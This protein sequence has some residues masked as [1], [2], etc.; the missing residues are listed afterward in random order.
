MLWTATTIHPSLTAADLRR[1][2]PPG[3]QQATIHT[4]F[5]MKEAAL[6]LSHNESYDCFGKPDHKVFQSDVLFLENF[7]RPIC[8]SLK[9]IERRGAPFLG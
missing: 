3:S 1:P 2:D 7:L 4:R 8:I 6:L 5:E 9:L